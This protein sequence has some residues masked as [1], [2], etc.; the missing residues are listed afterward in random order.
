MRMK[1]SFTGR[2]KGINYKIVRQEKNNE[3]VFQKKN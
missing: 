3:K 2:P 1:N